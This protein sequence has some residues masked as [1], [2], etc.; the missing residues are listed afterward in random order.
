MSESY[1]PLHVVFVTPKG[2]QTA[3]SRY[4]CHHLAEALTP[5][6]TVS[7]HCVTDTRFR[8]SAPDV[9]V[10]H[11]LRYH[12]EAD[13]VLAGARAV[14]AVT[15]ASVD[16]LIFSPEYAIQ[17]GFNSPPGDSAFY[18][19]N[20]AEGE[21]HL[22]TLRECDAVITSTEFLAN[23]AR[24]ALGGAK[25][26][27]CVR[28]FLNAEMVALADDAH[29][30]RAR[31]LATSPHARTLAYLSGSPTHNLDFAEIATAL[32]RVM[33]ARD[34]TRLLLVGTVALPRILEPFADAGRVR[35]HPF[36][37][38]RD[39][40]ALTAQADVTLAPLDASRLF[41]H[42]KSEIKALEAG[43]VGIPTL[44]THTGGAGEVDIGIACR[45][46]TDWEA[47][48]NRL[49]DDDT[50]AEG[51]IAREWVLANGTITSHAEAVAAIFG[52]ITA[53]KASTTGRVV[54]VFARVNSGGVG[55]T[56]R[57]TATVTRPLRE[58]MAES[59]RG[60]EAAWFARK[61]RLERHWRLLRDSLGG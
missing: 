45:S 18:H 29:T 49:L 28:N 53:H 16:D 1:P 24:I 37:P 59:L 32:A 22:R 19:Y 8:L 48:L 50:R 10:L 35:S 57:G 56:R 40:F 31:R 7:V 39:L 12:G 13:R 34:E 61:I 47:A 46:P 26:V 23:E 30:L 38:W 6:A 42:A 4:R 51:G 11:R 21:D 3:T 52:Q 44:A 58:R 36:V 27:H 17:I 55:V 20:R 9:V 15:V 5:G 33:A 14:G 2:F 25:P 43:A 60:V 54:T 41:N